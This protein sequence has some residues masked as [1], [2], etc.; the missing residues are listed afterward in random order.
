VLGQASGVR[1]A[2]VA[3]AERRKPRKHRCG[4]AVSIRDCS[5]TNL[6]ANTARLG[7]RKT[8]GQVP[9]DPDSAPMTPGSQWQSASSGGRCHRR[10]GTLILPFSG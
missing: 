5:F 6:F 8:A 4:H 1:D 10:R 3:G 2:K 9:R 7:T